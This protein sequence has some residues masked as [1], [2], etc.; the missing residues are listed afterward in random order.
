MPA[1]AATRS[2]TWLTASG[3]SKEE[4]D[5]T[6]RIA[7]FQALAT[8]LLVLAGVPSADQPG[9]VLVTYPDQSEAGTWPAVSPRR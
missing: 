5:T 9:T 7:T 3:R 1:P 4:Q 6:M 2:C 8:L